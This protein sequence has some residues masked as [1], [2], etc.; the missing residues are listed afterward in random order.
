MAVRRGGQAT[1]HFTGPMVEGVAPVVVAVPA[2]PAA[3]SV[4]VAPRGANGLYGWPVTL[5]ISDYEE[6]VEQEPNNEPA[7]ANRI[8]VPGGVTGQFLQS[9][10]VDHFVFSAKKSQRYVIEAQTHELH[11]PTEVYMVVKDDKGKQLAAS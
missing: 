1:I 11:S 3:T 8:S 6:V 2:D 9:G 7:H 4:A 5:A 10:D